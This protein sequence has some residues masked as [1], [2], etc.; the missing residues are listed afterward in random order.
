MRLGLVIYGD[1]EVLSGGYL[2]DRTLVRYLQE[3]GDEVEVISLPWR[4]YLAHLGDNFSRRFSAR[5]KSLNLD[6]LL[7]DELN[8]PSLAWLN[9]KVK[10]E[11]SLPIVAIVHHLR[12]SEPYH[13]KLLLPFYRWV[14]RHY[15]EALD[16]LIFNSQTTRE[17]V[18]GLIGDEKPG[19]V[20]YPG[21]D[22]L[23]PRIDEAYIRRRARQPGPLALLFV[24]NLIPRKG[25]HILLES[26]R[27]LPPDAWRLTVVGSLAMNPGYVRE[28]GKALGSPIP[29]TAI[30]FT[31]P[32]DR[33]ALKEVYSSH[34][35]LVVPSLY[36]GY[37][38]V[39][40]EALGFGLPAL[41]T[42]AG[43]AAE[44]IEDGVNGFLL[45]SGE[46][47]PLARALRRLI[48]D[49]DLLEAMSL[50]ARARYRELPTWNLS[51]SQIRNFLLSMAFEG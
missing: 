50:A 30:E 12:A 43:A 14:E 42:T 19:L 49:P 29:S 38:I 7:Q 34:Q 10:K 17:V 48:D 23:A 21:S 45:P 27:D 46:A 28:V 2:Y 51:C 26:L 40:G 39:Y 9:R 31:G 44:I 16:G 47:G 6:V 1:L 22:R 11:T 35:V 24:G 37:G 18:E 4:Q 3:A 33:E 36:E 8:H 15:L 5:I 13:P 32:L 25:F 20:A 41:A